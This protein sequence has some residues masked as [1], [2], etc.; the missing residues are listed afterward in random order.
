[1]A[2]HIDADVCL[3]GAGYAGLQRSL[4]LQLQLVGVGTVGRQC[5][6]EGDMASREI[7]FGSIQSYA[8]DQCR[9]QLE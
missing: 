5:R 7:D 8:E 9:G 1:M 4:D 6:N 3:V 2:E